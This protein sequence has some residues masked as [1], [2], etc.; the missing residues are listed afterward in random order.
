M[1]PLGLRAPP[2]PPPP[3][4][5]KAGLADETPFLSYEDPTEDR[6][7]ND[8]AKHWGTTAGHPR[9]CINSTT[10]VGHRNPLVWRRRPPRI[11][12]DN[13]SSPPTS[14]KPSAAGEKEGGSCVRLPSFMLCAG[15]KLCRM[16]IPRSAAGS[17]FLLLLLLLL[18]HISFFHIFSN[19]AVGSNSLDGTFNT[20]VGTGLVHK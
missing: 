18:W 15:F 3:L 7:D 20:P 2:P 9:S 19:P 16:E 12:D 1:N 6:Y 13:G 17:L 4:V 11:A 5:V 8:H 10:G 14:T